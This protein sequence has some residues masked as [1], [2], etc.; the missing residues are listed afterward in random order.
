M[1][2][3]APNRGGAPSGGRVGAGSVPTVPCEV[4]QEMPQEKRIKKRRKKKKKKRESEAPPSPRPSESLPR[5]H[6]SYSF[7]PMPLRA[8]AQIRDGGKLLPP[9]N[10]RQILQE[11]TVRGHCARLRPPRSGVTRSMRV[12]WGEGGVAPA[13]ARLGLCRSITTRITTRIATRISDPSPDHDPSR[14]EP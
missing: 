2:R 11:A 14:D 4:E 8:L 1:L 13:Q 3:P 12:G 7:S 5:W 10:P 9:R 6:R